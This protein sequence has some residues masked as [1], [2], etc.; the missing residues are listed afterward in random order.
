MKL[1]FFTK[2]GLIFWIKSGHIIIGIYV[3]IIEFYP[4][5]QH[6]I[7]IY[8]PVMVKHCQR[9]ITIIST[10]NWHN[11]CLWISHLW[12]TFVSICNVCIHFGAGDVLC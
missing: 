4:T 8:I 3:Y 1:I 5:D 2:F 11:M 10:L 9:P 12:D 7:L 6:S